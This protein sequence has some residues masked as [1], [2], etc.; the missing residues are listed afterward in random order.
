MQKI[1][2]KN[3][4]HLVKDFL[5]KSPKIVTSLQFVKKAPK[6]CLKS[7]TCKIS[8]CSTVPNYCLEADIIL[9]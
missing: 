3:N 7:S 6:F 5:P 1:E 2:K 4:S 8:G 9:W